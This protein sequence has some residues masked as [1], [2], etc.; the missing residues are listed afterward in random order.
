MKNDV[1]TAWHLV[2]F[3]LFVSPPLWV[4]ISSVNIFFTYTERHAHSAPLCLPSLDL[5][6]SFS[7]PFV[8]KTPP[9]S[10]LPPNSSGLPQSLPRFLP[11]S[12][13]LLIISWGLAPPGG[14]VCLAEVSVWR[15]G[16]VMVCISAMQQESRVNSEGIFQLSKNESWVV[17]LFELE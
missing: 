13:N 5:T 8:R 7:Y 9:Y 6:P 15:K 3:I 16:S 4:H 14:A 10:S 1:R 17:W 11:S 12:P 2:C